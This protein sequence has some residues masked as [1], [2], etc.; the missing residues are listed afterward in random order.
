[1]IDKENFCEHIRQQ[2]NAMYSLAFSV[3][4]NNADAAEIISESIFRAYRKIDSLK[5]EN[6]FKPW[7]LRIVHNTAVEFVRKNA[8]IV[9]MDTID[10]VDEDVENHL[11][12]TIS[13]QEAVKSLKQPYRTVV[14]LYYYE[15]FSIAQIAK[16]TDTSMVTVKQRLFRARKQLRE[17]LK[18]GFE[19][20][21]I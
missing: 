8:K 9:S 10:L 15:D 14:T 11:L 20:E 18:E 4:K 17:I 13:L 21:S 7:I 2:E 1:M 5:N 12:T 3:V 19:N 6:A 16:I